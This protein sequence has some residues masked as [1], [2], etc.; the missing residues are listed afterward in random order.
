MYSIYKSVLF[1]FQ[2]RSQFVAHL[3][4][5][6]MDVPLNVIIQVLLY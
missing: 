5:S 2:T 4:L 1:F 6:G 3:Y